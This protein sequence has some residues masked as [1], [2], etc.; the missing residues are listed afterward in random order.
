M[1]DF[2]KNVLA[3][4][5]GIFGFGL[6]LF[7]F[8]L[9]GLVGIVASENSSKKIADNSVLVLNLQGTIKERAD[10]DLLGKL[11]G[12]E[13]SQIGLNDLLSSIAKAK[14]NSHVKGIY[15]ETSALVNDYGTL[16]ELRN[17]LLDFKK[18]GKWIIAYGDL[19]TQGA[20]YIASVADKIYLNPSGMIDIHGIGSQPM[21]F[22]DL[23]AKFGIH[24]Q[25]VKVGAYKSAT[26]AYTSD[27][28]S[29]ANRIQL[30]A[31][32]NG[33]WNTVVKAI[34]TSRH[35]SQDSINSYADHLILLADPKSYKKDKLVDGFLYGDE[36][37]GVI[38]K[39]LGISDDKTISQVSPEEMDKVDQD[40]KGKEVA[41]YY[42]QGEIVLDN[43]A[44]NFV[45]Q[46]AIVSTKICKDLEKLKNDDDVK[47][48]VIRLSS[49]G[50]DAY[51]SEQIWHAVTE[52]KAKKPVVVSM[53]D[54]AASG[55]YYMS[56]NANWIVAQP[57]TLTGSIGIFGIIRDFSELTTKKLGLHF[58]QVQTN[59]HSV[60]GDTWARPLNAEE[61]R[62]VAG[63]VN[64][65]YQL[66]RTRV[67][68]GRKMTIPQVER[69]AQGHVWLG[70]DAIKIGLV[71]QLGGT[72]MAV[73]KA[74]QLAHLKDYH[75]K[76]YPQPCDW[77]DRFMKEIQHNNNLDETIKATLGD[78]YEPFLL[79]RELNSH[80]ELLQARINGNMRI[81]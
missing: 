40:D 49:P 79:L 5:V 72:D 27:R 37:K 47:A 1:K 19:Y 16:Q 41:V 12:G 21:Y 34:S 29:K 7:I 38:K 77:T 64:R 14:D 6:V 31:I 69:I 52:L 3:T 20:Y 32:I 43:T 15:I 44:S 25:V 76:G 42:A 78:Y 23:A 36:V 75:T 61:L 53:G 50:G 17:A 4:I 46:D 71:D 35:I 80:Q 59:K 39:K 60:F 55:G 13:L 30:T 63:N 73:A 66:F 67:A 58:D 54:M 28:M 10:D 70:M 33:T 68:N 9:L 62:L 18:S 51:A 8:G 24:Y 48:V 45:S 57:T 74:A 56:C 22:K 2:F 65:G 11:T 26:E 81:Q